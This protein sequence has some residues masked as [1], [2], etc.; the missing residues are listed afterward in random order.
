MADAMLQKGK[1]PIENVKQRSEA[2]SVASSNKENKTT[3]NVDPRISKPAQKSAKATVSTCPKPQELSNPGALNKEVM[4]ILRDLNNNMNK[5]NEKVEQQNNRIELI[6]QKLDSF[7]SYDDNN[8]VQDEYCE[9]VDEGC[10]DSS[11]YEDSSEVEPPQKKQKTD[12]ASVFKSLTDK[13]QNSET[14][15]CE[16]NDDLAFFVNNAFR[17]GISEDKQSEM[18]KDIHRPS[19]CDALVKTRVNQGIWRLLKPQTQTDDSKM[20]G[21]QTHIIKAAACMTKLLDKCGESLDSQD[22]EWG[23][24]SLALLGQ[25]NKQINN[26]RKEMHKPDLDPRYHYLT[27]ST[28]PFTEHLYGEDGDVNKNVGEINDLNRIGRN[29]SRGYNSRGGFRGRRPFR[30]GRGRGRWPRSFDTGHSGQY[31][32][33]QATS[34]N[35]KLGHKK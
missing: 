15:D 25:A 29:V 5:Q 34:K 31:A 3:T 13:F 9:I 17:N 12:D 21:I 23:T 11:L 28:L 33:Q 35:Q 10:D 18:T 22:L 8:G 30:R 6:S 26:K 4:L 24:N 27:S 20:Q 19:N 16:I 14:V 2:S 7:Y 1:S 32:G